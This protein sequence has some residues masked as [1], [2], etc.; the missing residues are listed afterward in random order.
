MKKGKS[1]FM[2]F[3][4]LLLSQFITSC[5]TTKTTIK[6]NTVFEIKHVMGGR[7]AIDTNEIISI[8]KGGEKCIV[9][10]KN[11]TNYLKV[12]YCHDLYNTFITNMKK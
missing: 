9:Y 6:P 11:T 12:D 7:I 8:I 3:S 10:L 4:V 2:I 1:V 5:S